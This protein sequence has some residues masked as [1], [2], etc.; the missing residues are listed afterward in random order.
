[1]DHLSE[2]FTIELKYTLNSR[3]IR[4]DTLFHQLGFDTTKFYFSAQHC[5]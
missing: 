4:I 5:Y 3:F 2:C 1:M